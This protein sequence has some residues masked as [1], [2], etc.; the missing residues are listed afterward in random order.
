[1]DVKSRR[2]GYICIG[3]MIALIVGAGCG[4]EMDPGSPAA[5][6]LSALSEGDRDQ[7][8][9]D[10]VI[11]RF[12]NLTLSDAVNVEFYA[13]NDPLE[14]IPDDLFAPENLVTASIGVAGTGIVQP[15]TEDAIAFPCTA[16][17]T[18]GTAGGSFADNESGEPRGLG[19]PRWAQEGP[20][21]LCG[22]VV[23]FQFSGSGTNFT[24]ILTISD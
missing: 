18:L 24:T 11:V 22:A 7:P 6:D 20:L 1:M 12:R 16:D 21:A 3:M 10:A 13:T 4:V 23:T 2:S 5:D 17:L 15:R 19:N 8:T 14:T 9:P